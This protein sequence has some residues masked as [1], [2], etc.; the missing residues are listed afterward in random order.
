MVLAYAVGRRCESMAAG[1]TDWL[2]AV[3][4]I[5]SA[6]AAFAAWRAVKEANRIAKDVQKRHEQGAMDL[7]VQQYSRESARQ[8]AR[9]AL[10]D[11]LVRKI[12]RDAR[13]SV[14]TDSHLE[15]AKA[16]HRSGATEYRTVIDRALEQ[17]EQAEGHA[18]EL[19][20]P[21]S[22]QLAMRLV[23]AVE[24]PID[25]LIELIREERR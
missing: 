21:A 25:V 5:C 15:V 22:L 9:V 19:C 18:Q 3:G 20:T 8:A 4:T 12:E 6:A 14:R 23:V 13:A 24:G 7:L 17:L 1:I 16:M 10:A 11:Q 2:S